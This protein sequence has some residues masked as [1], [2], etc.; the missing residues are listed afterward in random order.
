[1]KKYRRTLLTSGQ[2]A[3]YFTGYLELV[4]LR[5]AV[6]KARGD[7][8]DLKKFHDELISFGS[9]PTRYVKALMLNE[10]IPD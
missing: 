7:D 9:P 10:K 5:Q 6:E 8:F 4:E 2:L 1:M 3:T